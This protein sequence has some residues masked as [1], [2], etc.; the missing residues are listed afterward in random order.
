LFLVEESA[1]PQATGTQAFQPAISKTWRRV[2]VGVPVRLSTSSN[3]Q[4]ECLRTA[5]AGK[6]V[7]LAPAARGA[8]AYTPAAVFASVAAAPPHVIHRI[9]GPPLPLPPALGRKNWRKPGA[10]PPRLPAKSSLFSARCL[11]P[12]SIPLLL[13]S[14]RLWR[15]WPRGQIWDFW[16]VLPALRGGESALRPRRKGTR[17]F[18]IFRGPPEGGDIFRK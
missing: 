3:P 8:A 14:R 12:P 5:Q 15:R 10:L 2:F 16:P 17:L 11:T 4:P 7:F 18:R 6:P 9:R 13:I 1:P